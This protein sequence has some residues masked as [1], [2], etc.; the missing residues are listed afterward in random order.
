MLEM[1]ATESRAYPL[2]QLISGE[3]PVRLCNT[4][5]AVH[6]L[7]LYRVEPRALL[8]QVAA[9][10]PHTLLGA[11]LYLSVVSYDPPLNLPAHMPAGLFHTKT[12]TLLPAAMSF[13]ESQNTMK[14]SA[15]L[16]RSRDGRP[17]SAATSP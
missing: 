11:L 8:R 4:A 10:D 1:R 12:R 15:S 2:G 9:D 17:Q 16:R 6:P 3:Q 14:G 13:S 5:L 7:R